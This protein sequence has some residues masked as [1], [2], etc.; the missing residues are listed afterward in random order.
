MQAMFKI[1][2]FPFFTKS[3]NNNNNNNNH[4]NWSVPCNDPFFS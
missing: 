3:N 2:S 1:V 4:N